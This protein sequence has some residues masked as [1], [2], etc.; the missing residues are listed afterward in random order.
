MAI[1]IRS[2]LPRT[3]HKRVAA[4]LRCGCPR[5]VRC[6]SVAPEPANYVVATANSTVSLP[7]SSNV[8]IAE[9]P[10]ITTT[11]GKVLLIGQQSIGLTSSGTKFGAMDIWRN[12][13]VA[14][15][16]VA[17]RPY[18]LYVAGD[19]ESGF[20]P[21]V[22]EPPAGTYTYKLMARTGAF[23]GIQS[24]GP[25]MIAAI[26]LKYPSGE[27]PCQVVNIASPVSLNVSVSPLTVASVSITTKGGDLAILF[28]GRQHC[29][30]GSNRWT[31]YRDGVSIYEI[32]AGVGGGFRTH[33]TQTFIIDKVPAGTYEYTLVGTS[34][35]ATVQPFD[36]KLQFAVIELAVG[37][38]RLVTSYAKEGH[39]SMSI[40]GSLISLPFA[41]TTP[42]TLIVGC[43][44]VRSNASHLGDD[45]GSLVLTPSFSDAPATPRQLIGISEGSLENAPFGLAF[46]TDDL[47]PQTVELVGAVTVGQIDTFLDRSMTIVNWLLP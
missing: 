36:G 21:I 44:S 28:G 39:I 13:G 5:G 30:G 47:T 18:N 19:Q 3:G 12:D 40:A 24:S 6:G 17:Y 23:T 43:S 1:R 33:Q 8:V 7:A 46:L 27:L 38:R 26:E 35:S 32:S 11:G 41:P 10:P 15:T 42:P 2:R 9:T 20:N 22:D 37:R 31:V 4:V 34:T 45:R 29:Q 16:G 25:Q 14:D